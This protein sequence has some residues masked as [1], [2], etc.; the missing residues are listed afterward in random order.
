MSAL[1]SGQQSSTDE[2]PV[3]GIAGV[4]EP[5]DDEETDTDDGDD[6]EI[7]SPP[8]KRDSTPSTFLDVDDKGND[9]SPVEQDTGKISNSALR[10]ELVTKIQA[11]RQRIAQEKV[12]WKKK[13]LY[14]I[15]TEL[16][17]K[18]VKVCCAADV[19]FIDDD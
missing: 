17:N 9:K 14:R 4:A 3:R 18:L 8:P 11:T 5:S 15:Q 1:I 12:E 6:V 10:A 16:E 13:Y 7:V 19:I 2:A